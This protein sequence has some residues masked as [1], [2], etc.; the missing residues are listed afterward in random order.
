MCIPSIGR[1]ALREDV[2]RRSLVLAI[3]AFLL[4]FFEF[5]SNVAA[6]TGGSHPLKAPSAQSPYTLTAV[7]PVAPGGQM[8]VSWTAPSGRPVKDWVAL[9]VTGANNTT[10]L[11]WVYTQGAASGTFTPTAPATIGTYEFRY[12]LN[13][14]YNSATVSNIVVVDVP[15]SISITS[16][17]N[18]ASFNALASININVAASDS[19]GSVARVEFFQGSAKLGESTTSPFSFT[20]ANVAPGSYSLT[21]KATNDGGGAATSAAVN[22]SVVGG[23]TISGTVTQQDGSTP[24]VGATVTALQG[25]TGVGTATA[26]SSGNYGV[27]GLASGIYGLQTSA[28]GYLTQTQ[29]GLAVSVGSTTTANVILGSRLPRLSVTLTISSAG[30]YRSPIRPPALRS[31]TTIPLVIFYRFQDTLPTPS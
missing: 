31:T 20:W 9:Y 12:L 7:S 10:H 15:P 3:L 16:P 13:D 6:A 28:T 26:N 2:M 27:S 14:G 24:V 29:S 11:S 8:S 1:V 21:A 5:H 4:A 18:N 30:L 25:T 23:S 22:V 17:T 19:D